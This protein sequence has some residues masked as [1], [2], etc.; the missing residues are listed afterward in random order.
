MIFPL[1]FSILRIVEEKIMRYC[2]DPIKQE[3]RQDIRQSAAF[4]DNKNGFQI[5]NMMR[6]KALNKTQNV[7]SFQ[8][9]PFAFCAQY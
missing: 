7:K 1:H 4:H 5:S 8:I 3:Q 2:T 6:Q 9:T